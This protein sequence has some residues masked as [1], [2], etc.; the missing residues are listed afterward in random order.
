ML[1]SSGQLPKDMNLDL[2][3][4]A[5]WEYACRAGTTTRFPFGDD[6]ADLKNHAWFGDNSGNCMIDARKLGDTDPKAESYTKKI[7]ENGCKSH[8]VATKLANPWGL[9]DMLGNVW[10]WCA[11]AYAEKLPGGVDP[12]VSTLPELPVIRGGGLARGR[13]GLSVCVPLLEPS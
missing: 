7:L 4:E 8:P 5:Q 10:E 6:P 3:T 2:P 13:P 9:H 11:D 12:L 1:V